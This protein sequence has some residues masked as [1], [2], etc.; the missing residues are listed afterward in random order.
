MV[1]A[2]II[3]HLCHHYIGE[4]LNRTQFMEAVFAVAHVYD[5]LTQSM[6]YCEAEAT[7]RQH[8]CEWWVEC[9]GGCEYRRDKSQVPPWRDGWRA[10]KWEAP[11]PQQPDN[12]DLPMKLS[13]KDA[14]ERVTAS[15][16]LRV[17]ARDGHKCKACGGKPPLEVDHIMPVSAGGSGDMSN[18]QALCV[19]CNRKKGAALPA[20]RPRGEGEG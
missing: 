16:R 1:E 18:L 4:R 12:T 14:R 8:F 11:R 6:L 15:V 3:A 10:L 20:P 2:E 7:V 13:P 5:S 9:D 19:P 17:F